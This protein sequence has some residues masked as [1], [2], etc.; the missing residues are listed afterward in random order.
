MEVHGDVVTVDR[1]MPGVEAPPLYARTMETEGLYDRFHATEF[2]VPSYHVLHSGITGE[3]RPREEGY[4]I[5]VLNGITPVDADHT[6]YYYAFSR[7]FG[8]D[9]EW[10]TKELEVG[11]ATVLEEDAEALRLQEIGMK[12]RPDS[13]HDV[14]IGQDAGV[15]KARRLLQHKL[16][17]EAPSIQPDAAPQLTARPIAAS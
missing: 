15:A 3:G 5:K 10:A 4:L 12:Q 1:L 14:L 6:W 8:V 13:E 9:A 2:H 16:K 7:N 11:L 17:Q